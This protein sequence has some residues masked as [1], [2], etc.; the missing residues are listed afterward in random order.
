MHSLGSKKNKK[1]N[2]KSR[3]TNFLLIIILLVSNLAIAQKEKKKADKSDDIQWNIH[4][5]EIGLDFQYLDRNIRLNSVGSNLIFKKHIGEKKFISKNEKKA[6]RIQFG[7]FADYPV[8]QQ[9]SLDNFA[10][11]ANVNFNE[12]KSLN[13]RALI[14][15]EWQKQIKRIQLFYGIDAGI[16]YSENVNPYSITWVTTTGNV[17]SYSTND[18]SELKVP[19][20]IF[21][22]VKYFIHPRISVSLESALNVGI[23]WSKYKRT[24]YD[25]QFNQTNVSAEAKRQEINL[26]TDYLRYLNVSF[27]F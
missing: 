15:I 7:G 14:G 13:L 20:Y 3:K 16:N 25:N 19:L 9:D 27:H 10:G 8:G 12:G 24:N 6:L 11:L 23:G 2:Q 1:M 17:V 4:K 26:G 22:G 21:M 5:K 18:Q